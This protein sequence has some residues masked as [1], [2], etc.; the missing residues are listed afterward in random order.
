[1]RGYIKDERL[2]QLNVTFSRVKDR[3]YVQDR[4]G[5]DAAQTRH[6]IE[7]GGQVLVCGGREMANSVS[8]MLDR[9]LSPVRLSVKELKAVG[10]YREDVY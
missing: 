10:R 4:L 2:T 9:I 7:Q 6:L 5:D 3:A 8:E 1:M